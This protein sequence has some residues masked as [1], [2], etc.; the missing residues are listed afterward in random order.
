[1]Y[2]FWKDGGQEKVYSLYSCENV[3][4]VEPPL[5]SLANPRFII[6]A[7]LLYFIAFTY[8]LMATKDI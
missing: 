2:T 4:N 3:E 8:I 7:L 1:M 6:I 5:R